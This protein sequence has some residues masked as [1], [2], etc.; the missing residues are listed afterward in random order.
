[1]TRIE[2]F[3]RGRDMRRLTHEGRLL[4]I[5]G[6]IMAVLLAAALAHTALSFTPR[7]DDLREQQA[8]MQSELDAM[9]EDLTRI[10]EAVEAWPGITEIPDETIPPL[11]DPAVVTETT[12][13]WMEFKV[14]A[15][16]PCSKCCGKW[17]GEK[18]PNGRYPEEGR[19]VAAD[20]DVLPR[21]TVIEIE[22]VGIRTVEDCGAF[23]GQQL[24]LFFSDHEEALRWTE[25]NGYH[26]LKVRVISWP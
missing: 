22:G 9:Q 19:T 14:T 8:A 10:S 17:A 3:E 25:P 7:A 26:T 6:L 11:A 13:E 15:Y 21:G 4:V 20:L 18:L 12:A 23:R 2:D 16:C 24:D 5:A 1:M